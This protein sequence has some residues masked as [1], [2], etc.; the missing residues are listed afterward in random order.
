MLKKHMAVNKTMVE[1]IQFL[2]A[3]GAR[4]DLARNDGGTALTIA[5]ERGL[6]Y[7]VELLDRQGPNCFP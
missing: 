6:D 2:L 3:N 7:V 4:P 5:K 1:V